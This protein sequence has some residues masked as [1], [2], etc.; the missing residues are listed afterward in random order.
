MELS[1][2]NMAFKRSFKIKTLNDNKLL[3][4]YIGDSPYQ[5]A[6]KA[7]SEIM[8]LRQKNNESTE[9]VIR[10][11]LI[12]VTKGCKQKEHLYVGSRIKLEDPITYTLSNGQQIT[13]IF[14]NQLKKI[15]KCE[16]INMTDSINIICI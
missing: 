13:K 7:L 1:I 15:K 16:I 3:G 14:K 5:A 9:L 10:F 8:R 6:N 11:K 4:K 2:P 12:E